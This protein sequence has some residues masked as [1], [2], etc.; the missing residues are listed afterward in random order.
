MEHYCTGMPDSKS[1]D[2]EMLKNEI[3]LLYKASFNSLFKNK[4]FM[5]N[6]LSIILISYFFQQLNQFN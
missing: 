3:W 1:R 5:R 6:N 2:P 4:T